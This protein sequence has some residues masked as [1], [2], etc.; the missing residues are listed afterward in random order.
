MFVDIETGS[1]HCGYK[2]K[3]GLSH[4]FAHS[5]VLYHQILLKK[6]HVHGDVKPKKTKK[7]ETVV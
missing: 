2:E 4:V 7:E 1:Y 6:R 5:T 3:S